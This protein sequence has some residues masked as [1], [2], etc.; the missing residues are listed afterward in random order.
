MELWR[1]I[2]NRHMSKTRTKH[3]IQ[4]AEVKRDALAEELLQKLENC[5]QDEEVD[6]YVLTMHLLNHDD[7]NYFREKDRERIERIFGT[8]IQDT[9]RHSRS[10]QKI[11][12][13]LKRKL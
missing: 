6:I 5:L 2:S 11:L 10:L 1:L 13:T 12:E 3:H 4:S 7:M 8:L 9:K